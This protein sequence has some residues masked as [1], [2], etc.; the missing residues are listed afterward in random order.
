MTVWFDKVFL[1]VYFYHLACWIYHTTLFWPAKFLWTDLLLTLCVYPL[2]SS[3]FQSSLSL[4][5]IRFIMLCLSADWFLL[6]LKGSSLCL[7]DLNVIY[8]WRLGKFTSIIFSHK[9]SDSLSFLLL[10]F[11]WYRYCTLWNH[12]APKVCLRDPMVFFASPF[13]L[14]YFQ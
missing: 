10:G 7:L 11:L 5:F 6:I 12:W 14:H 1:A 2:G 3:C 13:Q 8:F 4:H 9:P